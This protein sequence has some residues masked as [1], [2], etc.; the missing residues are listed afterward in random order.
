M[1]RHFPE[2]YDKY[3]YI[4]MINGTQCSPALLNYAIMMRISNYI[5]LHT[6]RR[7]NEKK[8]KKL[9]AQ[10]PHP[11]SPG[12]AL[13]PQISTRKL[14]HENSK[15]FWKS[16]QYLVMC[17]SL[18][19]IPNLKAYVQQIVKKYFNPRKIIKRIWPTLT[20]SSNLTE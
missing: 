13:T 18:K 9:S 10:L 1:H 2:F 20:A 15:S 3:R 11:S 19:K 14:S 16:Y 17:N 7:K 12:Q 8:K 4:M 6:I 5:V